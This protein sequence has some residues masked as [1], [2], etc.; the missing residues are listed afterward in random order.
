[1]VIKYDK[2]WKEALTQ[3]LKP[4]TQFF[5]P[6]LHDEID[7]SI[8]PQFL[9]KELFSAK[10]LKK[11]K[12]EVDKLIKVRLKNGVEQ[13]IFVHI[14]FQTSGEAVICLRM[15][16]YYQ[17][18]RETYGQEIV[19]LVIYTGSNV[20]K[21]HDV[22][23]SEHFGTKITYNFNSYAVIKQNE[24]EL[25]ANDNPFAMI[26][27]ANYYVLKTKDDQERRYEFKQ[28]LYE[29]AQ[30]RNYNLEELSKLLIFVGELMKLTPLL[31]KKFEKE[32]IQTKIKN[33][34]D[35]IQV[36]QST[37]NLVNAYNKEVYGETMEE[38]RAKSKQLAKQ[39]A[40]Q[41]DE[42]LARSIILLYTRLEM[43]ISEISEQLKL[44]SE[45][46]EQILLQKKI[47]KK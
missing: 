36:S 31:E 30:N 19:A 32:V 24:D 29:L 25:L 22:Y 5:L 46:I 13:W 16:E 21:K 15:Y 4:F 1:M 11:P 40:K 20:P 33:D 23:E 38:A 37:K 18:I 10:N 43:S 44:E 26:V 41:L 6:Q 35:M 17:L 42:Q 28:K 7:W 47:I 12:K 3:F 2:Y 45:V 8:A 34:L 14:E 27:L 39:L 9:E